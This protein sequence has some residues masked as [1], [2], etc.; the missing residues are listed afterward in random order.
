MASPTD[1]HR[2]KFAR[3]LNERVGMHS[4][5]TGSATPSVPR[6]GSVPTVTSN[7]LKQWR[8]ILEGS[9]L[10]DPAFY[11]LR[12]PAHASSSLDPLEHYL[13]F[14]SLKGWD[15]HPLFDTQFYVSKLNADLRGRVNAL[16]HY[17]SSPA[18]RR[19]DPHPLFDGAFYLQQFPELKRGKISLLSH[20]LQVG[21]LAGANPNPLFDT[22]YYLEENPDVKE[23]GLNPLIHYVL[24]GAAE[25][26]SPSR[27]F[28]PTLY[29]QGNPDAHLD[30]ASALVHYL[31][32]GMHTGRYISP[33]FSLQRDL[34][35]VARI[36]HAA[37]GG[38]P[39]VLYVTDNF[40]LNKVEVALR[41]KLIYGGPAVCLIMHRL[42]SN[43]TL[44]QRDLVVL[45]LPEDGSAL[46]AFD[47]DNQWEDF[48]GVLN[49][50]RVDRLHIHYRL[51]RPFGL[52]AVLEALPVPYNLEVDD[53]NYRGALGRTGEA[54]S[55]SAETRVSQE[56]GSWQT[57][58]RRLS[59]GCERLLTTAV[60]NQRQARPAVH[61]NL[62]D[63]Q[64]TETDRT[65]PQLERS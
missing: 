47:L 51:G 31:Q 58:Y 24:A 32:S 14:G 41:L 25:G 7:Q 61:G 35:S 10:F 9:G 26:R 30:C 12:Y 53:S 5:K 16:V 36:E 59:S 65:R 33:L 29:L 43:R 50:L 64:S 52:G 23:S 57:D 20:F 22:T 34:P 13:R 54:T 19:V 60:P 3:W 63:R 2:T 4:S 48:V 46:C 62:I 49:W 17:V 40:H 21:W 37:R 11:C 15:P 1:L 56:G 6:K 18:P 39:V 8:K 28:D 38:Q 45:T 55:S 42:E 27:R 44:P